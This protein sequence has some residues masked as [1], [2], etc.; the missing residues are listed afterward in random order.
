[1]KNLE[2]EIINNEEFDLICEYIKL[3]NESNISQS[4]LARKVGIARS[5]IARMERNLHSI[6]LGTF[7]KLLETMNYKLEIIEKEDKNESR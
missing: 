3:R 5:T 7:V 2:K 1:M 6:S 4:E